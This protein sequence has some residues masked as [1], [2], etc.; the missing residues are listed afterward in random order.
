[1]ERI[2]TDDNRKRMGV[3]AQSRAFKFRIRRLK[4][5]LLSPLTI[6]MLVRDR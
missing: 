3:A 1:M 6:C 2:G 4:S 5:I